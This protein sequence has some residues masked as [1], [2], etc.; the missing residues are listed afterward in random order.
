MVMDEENTGTGE[1]TKNLIVVDLAAGIVG[2]AE[3]VV[4]CM[5]D[6]HTAEITVIQGIVGTTE[7]TEDAG[8][9]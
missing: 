3:I 1:V 8:V 7:I 6:M 2:T 9:K 4:R 5:T